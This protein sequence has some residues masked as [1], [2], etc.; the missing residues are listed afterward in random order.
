VNTPL[1][2]EKLCRQAIEAHGATALVC[3]NDRIALACLGYLK[4]HHL[5]GETSVAGFDNTAEAVTNGLTS[6]SFNIEATVNAMVA[7][8]L[9]P[10]SR[11][12]IS[13]TGCTTVAINGRV[14]ER[15]STVETTIPGN[16]Q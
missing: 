9:T 1:L 10:P 4:E 3:A 6:Y 15:A 2:T 16:V 11:T 7:H 12:S 13:D 5:E 14:M 8:V